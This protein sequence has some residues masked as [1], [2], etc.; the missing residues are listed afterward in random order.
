MGLICCS[1]GKLIFEQISSTIDFKP[2]GTGLFDINAGDISRMMESS[3]SNIKWKMIQKFSLNK[4]K[5]KQE[6]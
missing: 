5:L 2:I 1:I 6:P 3:S 4:Q